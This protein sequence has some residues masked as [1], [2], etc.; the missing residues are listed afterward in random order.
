MDKHGAYT[1]LQQPDPLRNCGGRDPKARRCQV[2]T[3]GSADGAERLE[4][5]AIKH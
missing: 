3:A 4:K 5:G 2:K 1:F